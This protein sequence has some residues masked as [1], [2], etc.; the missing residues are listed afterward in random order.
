MNLK[1]YLA[2]TV[3]GNVDRP[4]QR[5]D[6]LQQAAQQFQQVPAAKLRKLLPLLFVATCVCGALLGNALQ[7]SIDP[8]V[9]IDTDHYSHLQH[10]DSRLDCR[11]I[12]DRPAYSIC[13]VSAARSLI[14]WCGG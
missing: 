10:A 11:S 3:T 6:A 5:A 13:C 14:G 1:K 4:K 2:S 9:C 12:A 8:D 7:F